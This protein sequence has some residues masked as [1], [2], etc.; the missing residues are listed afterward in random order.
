MIAATE[1]AF[2]SILAPMRKQYASYSE[3]V[4]RMEENQECF[5]RWDR[6]FPAQILIDQWVAKGRPETAWPTIYECLHGW[7]YEQGTKEA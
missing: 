5:K 3:W 6:K 2:E 4:K 7:Q 1:T